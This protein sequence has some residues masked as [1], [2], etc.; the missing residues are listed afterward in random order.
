MAMENSLL[1]SL[2]RSL[3]LENWNQSKLTDELKRTKISIL[4]LFSMALGY[5]LGLL[6]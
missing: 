1:V 6:T 4:V 3:V 5:F 2:L